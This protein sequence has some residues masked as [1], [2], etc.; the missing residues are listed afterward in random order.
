VKTRFQRLLFRVG[1]LV[2]LQRGPRPPAGVQFFCALCR[3]TFTSA[4]GFG[5]FHQLMAA[6]MV[7]VTNLTPGSGSDNPSVKA[8]V[9]DT[10]C[11]PCNQSDTRE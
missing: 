8:P 11:G 6:S 4:V 1:Q 7:H 3:K 10:H 5:T 2:P 9:D